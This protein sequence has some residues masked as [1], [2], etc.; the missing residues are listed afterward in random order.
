MTSQEYLEMLTWQ[1]AVK[2]LDQRGV[3]MVD[4]GEG[5]KILGQGNANV[6][7]NNYEL[8]IQKAKEYGLYDAARQSAVKLYRA[9][10]GKKRE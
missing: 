2:A 3:S 5:K 9:E 4:Q 6:V 7:D 1:E 10:Q 8:A